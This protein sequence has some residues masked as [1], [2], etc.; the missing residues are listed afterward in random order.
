MSTGTLKKKKRK[1][2]QQARSRQVCC[3]QWNQNNDTWTTPLKL[4]GLGSFWLFSGLQEGLCCAQLRR[5]SSLCTTVNLLQH[6]HSKSKLQHSQSYMICKHDQNN[7]NKHTAGRGN[8]QD[9]TSALASTSGTHQS[10]SGRV[11]IHVQGRSCKT[12]GPDD[13][14][15]NK[16]K[17]LSPACGPTRYQHGFSHLNHFQMVITATQAREQGYTGIARTQ[18]SGFDPDWDLILSGSFARFQTVAASKWQLLFCLLPMK[19]H[20]V[21]KMLKLFPYNNYGQED[22]CALST[23][24]N[25]ENMCVTYQGHTKYRQIYINTTNFEQ[26]WKKDNKNILLSRTTQTMGQASS[27]REKSQE[28]MVSGSVA[29][30]ASSYDDWQ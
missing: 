27:K 28:V 9:W 30:G 3:L 11:H 12:C 29:V 16:V 19:D 4:V 22:V 17:C 7:N 21:I 10:I 14:E 1:K 8:L 5:W 23:N 18:G 6:K 25:T 2:Q 13:R 15:T 26:I 24:Y 20:A